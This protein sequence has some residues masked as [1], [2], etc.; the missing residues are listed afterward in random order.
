MVASVLVSV[1]VVVVA[2]AV[3]AAAVA[4]VEAA[5]GAAAAAG[6][7]GIGTRRQAHSAGSPPR[8]TL[9]VSSPRQ[10]LTLVHFSAQPKP[11]WS[12]FPVSCCLLDWGKIMH[13]TYFIKCA[14]VEQNSGR[15]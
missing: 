9:P 2:V 13:P 11:F 7:A 3:A 14:Y 5:G 6:A 10:G 15:V 4:G 1:V 8:P 12:H